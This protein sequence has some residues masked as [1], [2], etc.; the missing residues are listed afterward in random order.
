MVEG[1]TISVNK[2]M[3]EKPKGRYYVYEN[4][5]QDCLRGESPM[6]TE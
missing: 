4:G 2:G 5:L 3:S 6:V 1:H